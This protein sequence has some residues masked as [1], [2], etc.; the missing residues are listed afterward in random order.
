LRDIDGDDDFYPIGKVPPEWLVNRLMGNATIYAN[1]ANI[2]E[3]AWIDKLRNK[4]LPNLAEFK[5]SDIDAAA[6]HTSERQV[7]QRISR[8]MYEWDL[9]GIKYPSKF[10]YDIE[11]WTFF[12]PVTIDSK[13]TEILK[14]DD[15]DLLRALALH[16]LEIGP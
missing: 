6:L 13:A 2:Y 16:H 14:S 7:T 12:E 3:S 4:L 10:G 1:C 9:K 15:A 8:I 11:N 5:L